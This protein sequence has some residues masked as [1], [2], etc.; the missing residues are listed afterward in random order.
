MKKNEV[1]NRLMRQY[2]ERTDAIHTTTIRVDIATK[3][4]AKCVPAEI[5]AAMSKAADLVFELLEAHDAYEADHEF[6]E[7]YDAVDEYLARK[8]QY[9]EEHLDHA[10]DHVYSAFDKYLAERETEHCRCDGCCRGCGSACD[11]AF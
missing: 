6:D 10:F 4:D 8:A 9:Y 5:E 2:I 11:C 1:T 3:N 7:F